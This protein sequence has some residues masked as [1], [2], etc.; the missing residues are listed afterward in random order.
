MSVP[1]VNTKAKASPQPSRYFYF[2]AYLRSFATRPGEAS[3]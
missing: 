3:A 1:R 2:Y